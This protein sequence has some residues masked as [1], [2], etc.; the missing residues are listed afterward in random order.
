MFTLRRLQYHHAAR[1][2]GGPVRGIEVG[3]LDI[4]DTG[5]TAI[6]GPSGSGK[7]TLLS[8][9]AGFL[10]PELGPDGMLAFDGAPMGAEGHPPGRVAFVFQ[11]SL[12]LGAATGLTNALQGH[13]AARAADPFGRVLAA[14][15]T[16]GLAVYGV[17]NIGMVTGLLPVIGVPLPF[18]SYGGTAMVGALAA[19]GL[20]LSVD[21]A[22]RSHELWRARWDRSGTP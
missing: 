8:V 9:L 20:L 22:A 19:V 10:T 4:P 3:A 5:V 18:V 15:V 13:V 16:T 6:I 2:P 1:I 21:R 14:G 17:A 11:S 12:L 7:T